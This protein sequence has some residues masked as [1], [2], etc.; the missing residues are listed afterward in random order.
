MDENPWFCMFFLLSTVIQTPSRCQAEAYLAQEAA[1]LGLDEGL[2]IAADD[3]GSLADGIAFLP[4]VSTICAT[5]CDI[6]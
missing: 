5:P 3:V 2:R 1:R 4:A 6:I